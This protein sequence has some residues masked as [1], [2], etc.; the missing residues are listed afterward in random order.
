M[1]CNS[2]WDQI[3][4]GYHPH[5]QHLKIFC[6]IISW[7]ILKPFWYFELGSFHGVITHIN[8]FL[9]RQLTCLHVQWFLFFIWIKASLHWWNILLYQWISTLVIWNHFSKK[10]SWISVK[11]ISCYDQWKLWTPRV[12]FIWRNKDHMLAT[13]ALWIDSSI[14]MYKLLVHL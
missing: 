8:Y 11:I 3:S 5:V 10:T 9:F 7:R 12:Y 14:H 4:Y 6:V 13:T 2:P 1:Q